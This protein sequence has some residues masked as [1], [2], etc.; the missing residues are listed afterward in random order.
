MI[1]VK[2]LTMHYGSTI[3]VDDASFGVQKG[4]ILG[5]LGPNGAGK[6]TIMRILTTYIVPTSG[7]ATVGGYDIIE[8]PIEVR[9]MIG[10]LPET[11]PLYT[12]MQVCHY[13]KFVAKSR[14]IFGKKLRERMDWVVDTTG[15]KEVFKKGIGELSKGFRQRVGLAQALV[16]DPQVLILDE[17]T[18]GLDPLQVV[19]VRRL[20]RS[21]AREKTIIFSTHILQEVEAVSDRIV[22]INEGRIIADGTLEE[23][24]NRAK[25]SRRYI[26]TVEASKGA[27]VN[28]LARLAHCSS[29]K[30]LEDRDAGGEARGTGRT[31][32]FE[33]VC[34]LTNDILP[35]VDRLVRE[36]NW[37]LR[38]LKEDRI[39]MEETFI[40]L[41]RASMAAQRAERKQE[42]EGQA[43]RPAVREATKQ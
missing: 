36:E 13:L 34:P 11:I 25:K 21:L 10:Y 14:G 19:D 31:L 22:I 28:G 23:L 26:L 38:E 20:I 27:V 3:A 18:V 15:T 30:L 40:A 33:L 42:K 35:E 4:E 17:P 2:N 29:T 41:T 16:H 9:K 12:D 1:D 39:S 32:T 37:P 24:E 5:L 7:T 8:N 6:T 43:G